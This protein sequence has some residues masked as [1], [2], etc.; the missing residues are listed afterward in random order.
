[1]TLYKEKV[2]EILSKTDIGE[3]E[4]FIYD[5]SP[6]K[7]EFDEIFQ[8]YHET[9]NINNHYE[10]EPS[11]F[12]FKN[13]FEI[14]AA[15]GTKNGC[16]IMCI[17]MA[18]IVDCINKFKNK[19]DLLIN[20]DNEDF[21][22]FEKLLDKPIHELM[23]QMIL[24]FTFYHEMGHLVQ[25]SKFL[26]SQLNEKETYDA[27]YSDQSH[28][29]ELD[30]D[31]FSSLFLGQHIIDYGLKL[32][33]KEISSD[34]L[35]K[36]LIIFCSSSLFH[37]LSFSGTKE[38]YFEE[39]THPHPIIRITAIIMHIIHYCLQSFER[40]GV[41]LELNHKE[42]IHETF[43]FSHKLSSQK[44]NFNYAQNFKEQASQ[45]VYGITKYLEKFR[46]LE[47]VD[48]TLASHKWNNMAIKYGKG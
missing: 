25:K 22:K 17:N 42:I 12:F 33:N 16:Y 44:F 21:I 43:I 2:F 9:L 46:E 13:S 15:A 36:L 39:H 40:M 3:D 7:D 1:M 31:K 4:I 24:H 28:L 20:T 37:V 35:K 27:K 47:K 14:N 32:F 29:I 45:N 30:A 23:Y 18:A 34:Q 41:H 48:S 6:Y 11:F 10:I 26:S 38:I 8:F 5:T 19:T